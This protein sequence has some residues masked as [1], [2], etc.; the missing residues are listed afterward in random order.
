MPR[1]HNKLYEVI[2]QKYTDT[3]PRHYR[4]SLDRN[5]H[6]LGKK[7]DLNQPI[8]DAYMVDYIFTQPPFEASDIHLEFGVSDHAAVIGN[9]YFPTSTE[10]STFRNEASKPVA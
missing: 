7:T 4:S 8:F 5:L 9:I 3:I 6:R 2:T 10:R 1:G